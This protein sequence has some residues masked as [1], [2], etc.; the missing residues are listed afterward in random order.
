[1]RQRG[2]G[3]PGLMLLLAVLGAGL[4]AAGQSWSLQAQR[5]REAELR[6]RGEQIREAIARYVAARKPA[7][8]PPT[9]EA[10]LDDRREGVAGTPRHHL[11]RLWADPFTGD[12]DWVLIPAPASGPAGTAGIAGVHSRSEARR[13]AGQGVAELAPGAEPRVSDWRFVHTAQPPAETTTRGDS[14]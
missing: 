12:A 2:L 11:R 14:P 4:A 10:L 6:F 9:L 1:M 8:W 5:S 3:W 7:E 13:L